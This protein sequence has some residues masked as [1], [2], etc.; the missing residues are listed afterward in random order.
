MKPAQGNQVGPLLR[1]PSLVSQLGPESLPA[2]DQRRFII[3]AGILPELTC[4]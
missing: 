2:K 4:Q 3:W 1:L